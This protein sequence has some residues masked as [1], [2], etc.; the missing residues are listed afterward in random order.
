MENVLHKFDGRAEDYVAG[1]PTYAEAFVRSLF[2]NG[3]ISDTSVIAD[4]GCGTGKFAG[5]LLNYGCTVYGIE[6]NEEMRKQAF[7]QLGGCDRFHILDGTEAGTCLE[8]HFVDVVTVAQAFH[9]FDVKAFKKECRRI[10]KPGGRVYLI[11]NM[12]DMKENINQDA[13]VIFH[14]FC[15]EF[16]GFGG[17]IKRDDKRIQ[18][19]FGG[20][21]SYI[22][23]EHPLFYTE[24]AFL[25][26]S[27]SG[28]YSIQEGDT[29][30]QE[31]MDALKKLYRKYESNGK[32]EMGNQTVIYFGTI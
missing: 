19:F 32:I 10:L 30:F 3:V 7:L 8:D 16:K 26:R 15:P 1:R 9:W 14:D 17:G 25:R 21:Y 18:E 31:Y 27:L 11:W 6:P 23:F 4:I 13:F 28:S 5:Q 24:E 2:L 29:F 12:R 22:E 20:K